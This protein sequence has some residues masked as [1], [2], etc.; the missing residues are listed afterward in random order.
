MPIRLQKTRKRNRSLRDEEGL[1]MRILVVCQHYWP[2]P[3]RLPDICEELVKRGHQVK[4]I[5]AV[6]N[7]LISPMVKCQLV[8]LTSRS[9]WSWKEDYYICEKS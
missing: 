6:L 8:C 2:E 7:D 9:S 1:S 5:T 3:Y 4:V